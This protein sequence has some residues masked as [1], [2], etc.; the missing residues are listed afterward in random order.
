MICKTYAAACIG[1]QVVTVT[2]EADISAGVGLYIVGMPDIAVKEIE[3]RRIV[4]P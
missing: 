3:N 1:L 4:S 2:V